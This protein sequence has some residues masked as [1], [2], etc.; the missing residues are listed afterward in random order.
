MD[1][2]IE[3][4]IVIKN[5]TDK[6]VVCE[7][8]LENIFWMF[9]YTFWI[10]FVTVGTELQKVLIFI[11]SFVAWNS[12]LPIKNKSLTKFILSWPVHNTL[13]LFL[14]YNSFMYGQWCIGGYT[15]V[16]AVYSDPYFWI[17]AYIFKKIRYTTTTV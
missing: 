15:R 6:T 4:Y 11:L 7:G 16:Y 9:G 1:I 12:P 10:N 3:I 17:Y 13:I 5:R 2:D 8:V 14:N